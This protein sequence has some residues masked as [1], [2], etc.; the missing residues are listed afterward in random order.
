MSLQLSP[1]QRGCPL[2][3]Q[4]LLLAAHHFYICL[5]SGWNCF[6]GKQRDWV[7]KVLKVHLRRGSL[8][9]TTC[10]YAKWKIRLCI[11][12]NVPF[13][14]MYWFIVSTMHTWCEHVLNDQCKHEE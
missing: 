6:S 1:F 9:P 14:C 5:S 11:C 10:A 7:L 4:A 13:F 2:E 8:N 3:R 12:L